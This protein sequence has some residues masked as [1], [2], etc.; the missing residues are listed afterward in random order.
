MKMRRRDAA[1]GDV[2][3]ESISGLHGFFEIL[4]W[5][6]MSL[7]LVHQSE[8]LLTLSPVSLKV[9]KLWYPKGKNKA[10]FF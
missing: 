7:D 1:A 6:K 9:F 3:I 8:L 2:K 4:L 5:N 10:L